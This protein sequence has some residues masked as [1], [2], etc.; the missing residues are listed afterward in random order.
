M[1]RRL[2]RGAGWHVGSLVRD[3][4]LLMEGTFVKRGGVDYTLVW[5]VTLCNKKTVVCLSRT[6][7]Y[8]VLSQC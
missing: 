3:D 4:E 5:D 6:S 7:L 1:R 8:A 2:G